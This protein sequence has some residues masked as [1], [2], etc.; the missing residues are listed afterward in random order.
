MK[1]INVMSQQIRN[2]INKIE[3]LSENLNKISQ[4]NKHLQIELTN[5]EDSNRKTVEELEKSIDDAKLKISSIISN[6]T[7]EVQKLTS[8]VERLLDNKQEDKMHI[9]NLTTELKILN[10]KLEANESDLN[11]SRNELEKQIHN[12]ERGE[13]ENEKLQI[14][15]NESQISIKSLE[16]KLSDNS[17]LYLQLNDENKH[18]IMRIRGYEQKMKEMDVEIKELLQEN[19]VKTSICIENEEKLREKISQNQEIENQNNR[20]KKENL[21]SVKKIE[22]MLQ[23]LESMRKSSDNLNE[24]RVEH[25]K[26]LRELR[27][28]LSAKESDLKIINLKLEK[29]KSENSAKTMEIKRGS[30]GLQLENK[31]L[32]ERIEDFEK[33]YKYSEEQLDSFKSDLNTKDKE[34]QRNLLNIERQESNL[35]ILSNFIE[36]ILNQVDKIPCDGRLSKNYFFLWILF[37]LLFFQKKV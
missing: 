24:T 36:R 28:K 8:V 34:L 37:R 21:S 22:N 7:S 16:D 13:S 35:K 20:L 2:K 12:V 4:R 31:L 32:L 5:K 26:E 6:K 14:Y 10:D 15:L 29:S 9:M 25:E 18:Q 1:T 19:A 33:Q 30:D 17:A 27:K 23:E 3:E 11:N